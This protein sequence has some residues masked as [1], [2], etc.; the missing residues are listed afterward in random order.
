MTLQ[1][2]VG[3]LTAATYHQLISQVLRK[4]NLPGPSPD[5]DTTLK[6]ALASGVSYDDIRSD[7]YK[8]LQ[9]QIPLDFPLASF[10]SQLQEIPGDLPLSAALIELAE[11]LPPNLTIGNTLHPYVDTLLDPHIQRL[12]DELTL[13][14]LTGK[15]TPTPEN[16]FGDVIALPIDGQ[17]MIFIIASQFSDTQSLIRRFRQKFRDTFPAKRREISRAMIPAA[18]AVRQKIEGYKTKDIADTYMSRHPG[19]F[20]KDPRSRKYKA[21]KKRLEERINKQIPRLKSWLQALGDN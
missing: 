9:R 15:T 12:A 20:P 4:Y 10:L 13:Y 1:Q 16:S 3:E 11:K 2:I 8:A 21:A 19:K 5:E 7:F 18:T 17:P 14:A 6:E